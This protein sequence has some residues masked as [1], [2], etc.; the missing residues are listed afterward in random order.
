MTDDDRK[1]EE[2][3]TDRWTQ[4]KGN[5][6]AAKEERSIDLGWIICLKNGQTFQVRSKTRG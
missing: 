1:A 6:F 3:Q 2:G 4:R 5:S